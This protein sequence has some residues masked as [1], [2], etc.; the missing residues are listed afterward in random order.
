MW[1]HK[2]VIFLALAAIA[3]GGFISQA[4]SQESRPASTRRARDQE[5]MRVRMEEARLQAQERMKEALGVSD[6]EWKALQ[7]KIEKVQT[8][9]RQLRFG[10]MGRMFGRMRRG[11]EQPPGPPEEPQSDV[12]IKAA[13]LQ[14]VLQEE[15][16]KPEDIKTALTAYREARAKATEELT[17]AQK[18]L[19]EVLTVKQEAQLVLMGML[20]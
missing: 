5:Q 14:K 2:M 3:V 8:L 19:Q 12:E 20:E 18:E 6:E 4:I 15:N 1:R 17:K 16:P 13:D 9:N 10:M 7:P 11:G